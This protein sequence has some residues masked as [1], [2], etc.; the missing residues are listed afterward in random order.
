MAD[1]FNS[2]QCNVNEIEKCA[3][4]A[5]LLYRECNIKSNWILQ[6]AFYVGQGKIISKA[7]IQ[8]RLTFLILH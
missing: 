5:L 1:L 8:M 2:K 6:P 3:V 4:K 7:L